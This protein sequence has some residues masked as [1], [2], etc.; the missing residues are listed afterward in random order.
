MSRRRRYKRYLASSATGQLAQIRTRAP[1]AV[2]R[3]V[4]IQSRPPQVSSVSPLPSVPLGGRY[5]YCADPN[6]CG[7]YEFSVWREGSFKTASGF[8]THG[9]V[10]FGAIV[11]VHNLEDYKRAWPDRPIPPPGFVQMG[12]HYCYV[13]DGG[14]R[15][16]PERVFRDGQIVDLNPN[17]DVFGKNLQCA[18]ILHWMPAAG[19]RFLDDGQVPSGTEWVTSR[20]L[21]ETRPPTA[22]TATG[23]LY[24]TLPGAQRIGPWRIPPALSESEFYL[25]L[26][27]FDPRYSVP[28]LGLAECISPAGCFVGQD[29]ATVGV[30]AGT[31]VRVHARDRARR[32]EILGYGRVGDEAEEFSLVSDPNEKPHETRFGPRVQMFWVPSASLRPVVRVDEAPPPRVSPPVAYQTRPPPVVTATGQSAV[33]LFAGRQRQLQDVDFT[34][35]RS[36]DVDFFPQRQERDVD[37]FPGR[38]RDVD[39]FQERSTSSIPSGERGERDVDF[40][41]ERQRDEGQVYARCNARS[42]PVYPSS[43]Y[44]RSGRLITP[45]RTIISLVPGARVRVLRRDILNGYMRPENASSRRWTL[46]EVGGRQGWVWDPSLAY[47]D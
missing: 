41:P 14:G 18:F 42:C 15:V 34:P 43:P 22:V 16:Q 11:E 5:A 28:S 10:P 9:S 26:G 27:S 35:G 4:D 6:G 8:E 47:A 36:R 39:F 44:L 7:I 1:G 12:Y 30:P 38:Q 13:P 19:L 21:F 25:G 29:C 2:S 23:Q 37:F 46:V 24:R 45:S 31:V 32:M 40:F 33:D 3:S 17:R 20:P